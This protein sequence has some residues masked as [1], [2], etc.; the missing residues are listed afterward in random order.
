MLLLYI[1]NVRL[2]LFVNSNGYVYNN[3]Y[4][5]FRVIKIIVGGYDY[6]NKGF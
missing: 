4:K 6:A 5:A 2:Y 1:I 3:R